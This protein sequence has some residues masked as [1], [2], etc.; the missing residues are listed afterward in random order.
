MEG[1][2]AELSGIIAWCDIA[3]VT[4]NARHTEMGGGMNLPA[5]QLV[6][7]DGN[8]VEIAR[9]SLFQQWAHGEMIDLAQFVRD[10]LGHGNRRFQDRR[11]TSSRSRPEFFHS[12][13]SA[14]M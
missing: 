8:S 11:A 9:G 10:R 4:T 7:K 6:L 13:R 3:D 2:S 5:T 12:P 1:Q 14:G